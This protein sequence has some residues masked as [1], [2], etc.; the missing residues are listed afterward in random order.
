MVRP[1]FSRVSFF[2]LLRSKARRADYKSVVTQLIKDR[3]LIYLDH[4]IANAG[5]SNKVAG[6]SMFPDT[7]LRVAF[8]GYKK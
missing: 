4:P 8:A 5:I 3:P 6:V 2:S 7:L 1:Y